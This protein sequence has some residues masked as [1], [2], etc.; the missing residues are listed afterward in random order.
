VDRERLR[1]VLWVVS[2]LLTLAGLVFFL[3]RHGAEWG[4]GAAP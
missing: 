3:V 2:L 1:R 4:I